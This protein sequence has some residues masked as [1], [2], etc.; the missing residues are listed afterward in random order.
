MLLPKEFILLIW[1]GLRLLVSV[2]APRVN[3]L[4]FKCLEDCTLMARYLTTHS[5]AKSVSQH[6]PFV[7]TKLII[8]P[9]N[10]FQN[11]KQ[12]HIGCLKE[13]TQEFI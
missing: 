11:I 2:L 13:Q 6:D 3:L 10:K 8:Q 7:F 5:K 12:D 4:P 9:P 1:A